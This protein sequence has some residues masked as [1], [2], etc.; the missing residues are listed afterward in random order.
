MYWLGL[1]DIAVEGK[2]VWQHSSKPLELSHWHRGEPDNYNGVKEDCVVAGL[3][4]AGND[5]LWSDVPC[6]ANS[7]TNT[8][9]HTSGHK[10]YALCQYC[11]E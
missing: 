6:N 1:T 8:E 4:S 10:V 7:L 5:L 3:Y 11:Q 9:N 2:Y